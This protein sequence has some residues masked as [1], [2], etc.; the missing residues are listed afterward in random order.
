MKR[1]KFGKLSSIV[2]ALLA[3]VLVF[4]L[5][6]CGDKKDNGGNNNGNGL[7]LNTQSVSVDIG[8]SAPVLVTSAVTEDVVWSSSNEDVAT[9]VGSGN[10]KRMGTVEGVAAGTATITAT[11]GGKSATCKVTVTEAEVVTITKDGT[12]APASIALTGKDASVQLAASS[13]KNH[14]ITWTSNKPLIVSVENGLVK[15]LENSG[16]A[17]VTAQCST[18]SDV[19]ATVEI[20]VGSGED[21]RYDMKNGTEGTAAYALKNHEWCAWTEWGGIT[22]AVYDN[23][24]VKFAFTNNDWTQE[25]GEFYCVQLFYAHED[26][27]SFVENTTYK[28]SF[29]LKSNA[30]GR[31]TINGMQ[32][33]IAES[34]TP[35]EYVVYYNHN[36][37]LADFNMQFGQAGQHP[38]DMVAGEF[39]LSDF[40]WEEAGPA[41]KLAAPSFT[42]DASTKKIA[43]TDSNP[44]GSCT[45]RLDF[46]QGGVAK[47]SVNVTNGGVVSTSTISSNGEYDVYLVAV[48]TNPHFTNS[49]K[50]TATATITV[51][52]DKV[53]IAS[54]DQTAAINAP[55]S[56][57]YFAMGGATVSPDPY[58]E[59][60]VI[61]IAYTNNNGNGGYGMQMF[62][63]GASVVTGNSYTVTCKV[64]SL[65]STGRITVN[66]K[67]VSFTSAGETK[68]ITVT[69]VES[70]GDGTESSGYT[71]ASVAI[72][73]GTGDGSYE[74]SEF[75]INPAA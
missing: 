31:V 3:L 23:G 45:Y 62:Y 73:F 71:G 51:S 36:N 33:R 53:T 35:V 7:A 63:E 21:S 10:G 6:A 2:C 41:V 37:A 30:A 40:K 26:R 39:E 67:E 15:A 50:S 70:G 74:I 43:I 48:S 60:D 13:S 34:E 16:T 1:L 68:E 19:L 66:G 18:H 69:Y 42:Y 32:L 46:Y 72:V 75:A 24:V 61:H 44:A 8:A 22:K 25:G 56:W 4:S 49:D 20:V 52:N 54:G 9:V 29:K 17:I 47:G 5:A 12:A 38:S 55:G 11:S 64:K 58:I 59:N 27:S 57:R 28:L 14:E 65:G